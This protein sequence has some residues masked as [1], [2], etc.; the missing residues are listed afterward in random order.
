MNENESRLQAI[1]A[2]TGLPA[3]VG[4]ECISGQPGG[5]TPTGSW[6]WWTRTPQRSAS[7]C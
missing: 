3:G 6:C 4:P 7:S 1:A 5:V 2:L